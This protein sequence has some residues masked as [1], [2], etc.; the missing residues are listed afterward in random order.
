MSS[1]LATR[2]RRTFLP[3]S[4]RL[5][6]S[7]PDRREI[8]RFLRVQQPG[9]IPERRHTARIPGLIGLAVLGYRVIRPG[10]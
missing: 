6:R 7:T 3:L 10:Q 2:S 1:R 5:P 9:S 4:L 8:A